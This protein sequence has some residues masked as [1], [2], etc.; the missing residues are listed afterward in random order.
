M[1]GQK[2]RIAIWESDGVEQFERAETDL[3]ASMVDVDNTTNG[4]TNDDAQSCLEEGDRMRAGTVTPGS[5]TGNPKKATV[6][7]S[8]ALPDTNY[9][10]KIEGGDSRV[11]S[12]ESKTTTGFVINANANQPLT[13]DVDWEAKPKQDI[14]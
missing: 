4:Y 9:T 13:V 6:T 7:F 10:I 2:V 1:S 5:F 14:A 8:S 3:V 12:W 11:W